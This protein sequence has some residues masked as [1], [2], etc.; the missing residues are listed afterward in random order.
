MEACGNLEGE[1]AIEV[2][3]FQERNGG[4]SPVIPRGKAVGGTEGA[5]PSELE[6]P[7]EGEDRTNSMGGWGRESGSPLPER[8]KKTLEKQA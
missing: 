8:L 1:K 4:K 7:R 6:S 2:G 5:K 3:K